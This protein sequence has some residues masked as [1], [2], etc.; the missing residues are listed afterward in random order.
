MED[1]TTNYQLIGPFRQVITLS[2][3]A[4]RGS[5]RDTQLDII[6]EGGILID[7][8]TIRAVGKFEELLKKTKST[9]PGITT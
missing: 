2:E 9:N 6:S 1:H 8:K 7:D 4:L 5:L 3:V